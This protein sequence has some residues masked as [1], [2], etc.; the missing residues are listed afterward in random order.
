[1]S[2]TVFTNKPVADTASLRR[3][4]IVEFIIT[5]GSVQFSKFRETVTATD[6]DGRSNY[7][8][9]GEVWF[10]CHKDVMH[11]VCRARHEGTFAQKYPAMVA[12]RVRIVGVDARLVAR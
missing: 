4:D 1:M 5:A 8:Q 2:T 12:S 9:I 6:S 7:V 11:K 10:V 3:G